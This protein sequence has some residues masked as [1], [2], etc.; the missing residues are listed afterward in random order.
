MPQ[1]ERTPSASRPIEG[2]EPG[3]GKDDDIAL[4]ITSN[5]S[6]TPMVDANGRDA[7]DPP[8]YRRYKRRFFGLAQLVLLNIIV[9]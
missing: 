3:D 1:L 5:D 7:H 4:R 9:S 6:S 8:Q 2:S